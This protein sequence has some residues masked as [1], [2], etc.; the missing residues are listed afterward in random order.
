MKEGEEE[1]ERERGKEGR[2]E[3]GRVEGRRETLHCCD[4][5]CPSALREPVRG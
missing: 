4:T 3:V 2:M 5:S 1:R